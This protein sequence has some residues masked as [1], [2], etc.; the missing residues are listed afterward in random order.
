MM[1]I[2]ELFL[3]TVNVKL[4]LKDNELCVEVTVWIDNLK[5]LKFTTLFWKFIK[6]VLLNWIKWVT[7]TMNEIAE[8]I[9]EKMKIINFKKD[10]F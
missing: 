4:T 8:T 6:I 5:I 10:S 2:D 3:K 1:W 9:N 7:L